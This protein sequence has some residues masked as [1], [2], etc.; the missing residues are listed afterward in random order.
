MGHTKTPA[1]LKPSVSRPCQFGNFAVLHPCQRPRRAL[2]TLCASFLTGEDQTCQNDGTTV[3]IG[4]LSRLTTICPTLAHRYPGGRCF[5]F[6]VH[7]LYVPLFLLHLNSRAWSRGRSQQARQK[8]QDLAWPGLWEEV[9]VRRGTQKKRTGP[10]KETKKKN[11]LEIL[12]PNPCS[13][14]ASSGYCHDDDRTTHPSLPLRPY[15]A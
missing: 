8:K 11:S 7:R 2:A 1:P 14:A 10:T 6:H 15:L 13:C 5:H 3:A 12:S 9:A 4:Q